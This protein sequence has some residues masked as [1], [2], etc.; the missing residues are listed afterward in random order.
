MIAR[1]VNKGDVIKIKAWWAQKLPNPPPRIE[2]TVQQADHE[3]YDKV[4]L[5]TN[6]GPFVFNA[7]E[8]IEVMNR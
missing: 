4:R 2:V 3:A 8:E 6:Q 7:N 5:Y 1:E